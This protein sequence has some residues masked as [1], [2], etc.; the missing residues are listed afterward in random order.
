MGYCFMSG[1]LECGHIVFDKCDGRSNQCNDGQK[2]T[3]YAGMKTNKDCIEYAQD[4]E[5]ALRLFKDWVLEHKK[6]ESGEL[7]NFVK[8]MVE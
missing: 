4:Y 1:K 3:P 5:T 2:G 7:V 6:E 8:T